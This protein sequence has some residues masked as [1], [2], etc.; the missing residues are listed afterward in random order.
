VGHK[1]Q[2]LHR[3]FFNSL[4]TTCHLLHAGFFL[5]LFF[6]TLKMEATCSTET[7]VDFQGTIRSYIP[8]DRTLHNDN[9][10]NIKSNALNCVLYSSK[11]WHLFVQQSGVVMASVGGYI[12][13]S[14]GLVHTYGYRSKCSFNFQR[15]SFF[16]KGKTSYILA[17]TV[18]FSRIS[19]YNHA[20]NQ[21]IQVR[22]NTTI[23]LYIKLVA[24]IDTVYRDRTLAIN[25]ETEKEKLMDMKTNIGNFTN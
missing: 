23:I 6:D 9:C 14:R 25:I 5:G 13:I 18:Y 17:H 16:V 24:W 20:T 7:S 11:C 15:I 10:G 1:N 12:S 19:H 21:S 3:D 22:K 2:P 8:E 4:S